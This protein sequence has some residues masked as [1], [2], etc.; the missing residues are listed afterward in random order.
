MKRMRVRGMVFCALFAA[1]IGVCAQVQLPLPGMVPVSLATLGVMM[2]GLLLGARGG[3]MAV[4]VYLL[5]GAA[6]VPVFA[7]FKGGLAV[8]AGPT[9]GYLTG[10]LPCAVLSGLAL[11]GLQ[12]RF[13][14]RC[15]LAALGAA[16]CIA[17]GTAWFMHV[18]GRTLGESLA[19]C[20]VPFLP[21]DAAKILLAAFL[22]PR[23]RKALQQKN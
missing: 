2:S 11:P 22:S 7:G 10:Y 1:L 20:V 15:L 21:G 16:A 17:A 14:G 8:L 12:K 4:L 23:L 5:L 9:G 6:G 19:A 3:G 18:T 13:G